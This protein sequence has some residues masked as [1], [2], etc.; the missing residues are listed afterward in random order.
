MKVIMYPAVT[1]DGFIADLNGECYSWISDEDEKFYE[2]TGSH[3]S[4][5]GLEGQWDP[6]LCSDEYV[7]QKYTIPNGGL[8]LSGEDLIE[9]IVVGLHRK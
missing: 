6:E 3:C 5:Y 8:K 4:C 1:L 9:A 7:Q 2:V